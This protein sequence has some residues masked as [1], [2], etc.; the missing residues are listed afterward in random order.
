MYGSLTGG[1]S[2]GTTG[3]DKTLK[4]SGVPADA[5]ATGLALE[6]KVT[7]KGISLFINDSGGLA[8]TYDDG[9]A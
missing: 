5:E 9:E 1:G 2:G 8:A 6:E 3:T 4:K 7:G